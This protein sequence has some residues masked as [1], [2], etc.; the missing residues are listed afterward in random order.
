M[1]AMP[2]LLCVGDGSRWYVTP[3]V[4]EHGECDE[5][6]RHTGAAAGPFT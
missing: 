5:H 2:M 4:L 1:E 3:K 6:R